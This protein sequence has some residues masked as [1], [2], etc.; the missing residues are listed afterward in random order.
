MATKVTPKAPPPN[1]HLEELVLGTTLPINCTFGFKPK[2]AGV[3]IIEM[4]VFVKPPAGKK[5]LNGTIYK[6][7]RVVEV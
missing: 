5:E 4:K 6:K 2:E 7:I 1:E 3:F